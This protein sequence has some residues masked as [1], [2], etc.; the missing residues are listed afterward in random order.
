MGHTLIWLEGLAVALMSLAL[1]ASWAARGGMARI[2]WVAFVSFVFLGPAA[3]AVLGTY[4][5]HAWRGSLVQTSWFFYCLTW[6]LA[7]LASGVF[8]LRR[9]LRRPEA[10]QARP[11]ATWL[12]RNLWLGWGGAVLVFVLTFWNMDLAARADLAIAR[13]EAGALLLAMT[14]SPV[15]ESEN[16]ALVYAE[17]IKD[18]PAPVENPWYDAA[19]R[20]FDA[21]ERVDWKDPALAALVKKHEESLALLR[22]AAAM[23]KCSFDRQRTVLDAVSDSDLP[24]RKIP[25]RGAILLAL[26]ARVQATQG[27][28]TRAFEDIT[29]ILGILRHVSAELGLVWVWEVLA[30]RTLEEVLSLAPPGKDPLPALAIP[31]LPPLVRKVRE[32]H[33]LLGM[34]FPAAASQPSLILDNIRKKDGPWAAL[35]LETT[36]IPTRVFIIPDE[37]AAMRKLFEGYYKSPRS[38]RDETPKDWADLR[39]SVETDPTGIYGTYYIK[40]KHQVLLAEGSILATLRQTAQAGLAVAAYQRKS[41]RY[42][43]RLEQLVPEFLPATPVDPR[44]GQPLHLKRTA[45][46]IIVYAPQ[47]SAGV[48]AGK[49]KDTESR[50]RAPIFRLFPRNPEK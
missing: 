11:A 39:Q 12:R 8:L 1:A 25:G 29:A 24:M 16:A 28:L 18:L 34:V 17:A 37:V 44:D 14:A 41:G 20:G 45:D 35:A 27:N 13:Q 47:E 49:L 22:K 38:S 40:P 23:P 46:V 32:E 21:R 43:E 33:A 30:W 6:L 42:P 48:E 2:L 19:Q 4:Q 50:R 36:V 5:V 15:A 31:E 3:L 7:F 10:G 26:D 9:A